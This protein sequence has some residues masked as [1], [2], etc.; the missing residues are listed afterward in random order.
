MAARIQPHGSRGCVSGIVNIRPVLLSK[1]FHVDVSNDEH[2]PLV[3]ATDWQTW[4]A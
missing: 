3:P 4:A 1:A 2:V